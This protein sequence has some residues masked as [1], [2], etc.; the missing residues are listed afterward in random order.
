MNFFIAYIKWVT[1]KQTCVDSLKLFCFKT[2]MVPSKEKVIQTLNVS[3]ALI[4]KRLD[5]NHVGESEIKVSD[6]SES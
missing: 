6:D 1:K 3:S 4:K 5:E 2:L